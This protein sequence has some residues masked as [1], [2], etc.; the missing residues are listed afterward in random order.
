[1]VEEM[2]HEIAQNWIMDQEQGFMIQELIRLKGK[3]CMPGLIDL[4]IMNE[5]GELLI[6]LT[7]WFHIKINNRN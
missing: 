3:E 7:R 4:G 6:D 5:G 1:M 2:I